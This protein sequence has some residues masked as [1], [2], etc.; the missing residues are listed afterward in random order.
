[1]EQAE[2]ARSE[3]EIRA[4][5]AEATSREMEDQLQSAKIEADKC[6]EEKDNLI[7]DLHRQLVQ[8][9]E[10]TRQNVEQVEELEEYVSI[11]ETCLTTQLAGRDKLI[12]EINH[13]IIQEQNDWNAE[14]EKLEKRCGEIQA[15]SEKRRLDL[16]VAQAKL[17]QAEG[18]TNAVIIDL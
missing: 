14:K 18:E 16:L 9:E 11:Q 17:M 1:M 12:E 10:A 2:K 6:L 4:E 3:V 5:K 13:K 7:Q 15:I 8:H